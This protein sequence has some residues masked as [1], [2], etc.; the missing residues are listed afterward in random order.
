MALL[1]P[2]LIELV[3]LP[4]EIVP[5]LFHTA[6]LSIL[7]FAYFQSFF[8]LPIFVETPISTESPKSDY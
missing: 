1:E 3:L 6:L 5:S 4:I 8:L 2:I 7:L